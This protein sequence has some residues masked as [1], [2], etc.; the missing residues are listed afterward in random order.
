MARA[1]D[2]PFASKLCPQQ[3]Q[4]LLWGTRWLGQRARAGRARGAGV[5]AFIYEGR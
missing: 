2:T 1:C 5:V 3:I 4:V